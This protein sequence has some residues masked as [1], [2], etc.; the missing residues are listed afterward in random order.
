[1][2]ILNVPR[3]VVT[4][5]ILS[6]ILKHI[7]V[8]DNI[9]GHPSTQITSELF[10]CNNTLAMKH[11]LTTTNR[12]SCHNRSSYLYIF[13]LVLLNA[14]DCHPD[15]VLRSILARYAAKH[16]RLGLLVSLQFLGHL[17]SPS[18]LLMYGK[19]SSGEYFRFGSL[20]F[21]F[22]FLAVLHYWRLLAERRIKFSQY[23]S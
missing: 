12:R 7:V 2:E 16:V 10:P 17:I 14:N 11:C 5:V 13:A 8:L 18:C 9:E 6:S 21:F 22:T 20:F 1:M 3:I 15:P 19:Q 23:I 4:L